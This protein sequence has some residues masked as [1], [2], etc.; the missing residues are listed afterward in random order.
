MPFPW[1]AVAM[2]AQALGSAFGASNQNRMNQRQLDEQRR[3]FDLQHAFARPRPVSK[4]LEDQAGPVKQL[5]LPFLLEIAL[6]D[7]RN[8]TIDQHKTHIQ[9]VEL[10][11][12]FLHLA[13]SE[14][15]AGLQTR[16]AHNLG[17]HHLHVG[18]RCGKA[19]GFGEPV[20][21]KTARAVVADI[22]MQHIGAH[23]LG[24]GRTVALFPPERQEVVLVIFGQ[25]GNQSSPS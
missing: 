5:D 14:Q 10:V 21:G 6:L 3:Q 19:Y 25:V 24:G 12:Q 23:H 13:R 22:G 7:G 9:L 16:Q 11:V 4:N 1:M 20:L 18:K 17:P 2:G 15:H 8:R